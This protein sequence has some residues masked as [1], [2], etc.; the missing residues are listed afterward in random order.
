ML[1]N[2]M[3]AESVLEKCNRQ[4]YL[5]LKLSRSKKRGRPLK[6]LDGREISHEELLRRLVHNQA[7]R[8]LDLSADDVECS[9]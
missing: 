1:S 8:D 7:I 4:G 5:K 9:S 2:G 3:T 6:T